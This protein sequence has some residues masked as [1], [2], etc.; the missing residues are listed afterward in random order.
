MKNSVYVIMV[1]YLGKS[2]GC[3]EISPITIFYCC[4]KKSLL[5]R[6]L[7]LFE[8]KYFPKR[9]PHK[10]SSEAIKKWTYSKNTM[11]LGKSHACWEISPITIF[12]CCRKK[13]PLLRNLKFFEQ[14]YF[15]KRFPHKISSEAIKKQPNGHT[16]RIRW[17]LDKININDEGKP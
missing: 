11:I 3:W 13:S 5:L 9:F 8:Q 10:I 17:Y 4:R 1:V 7:K 16:Q 2:Y 14:K 6:N 15:P 12:Y